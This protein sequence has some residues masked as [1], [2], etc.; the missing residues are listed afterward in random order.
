M[1]KP[2]KPVRTSLTVAVAV[3]ELRQL[4]I[5]MNSEVDRMDRAAR[6][7]NPDKMLRCWTAEQNVKLQQKM[8]GGK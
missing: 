7:S 8:R 5:C 3:R 1:S 2:T 6:A 4:A